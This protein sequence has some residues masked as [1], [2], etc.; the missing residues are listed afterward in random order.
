MVF[1]S[2]TRTILRSPE[3]FT[4]TCITR[5]TSRLSLQWAERIVRSEKDEE[6]SLLGDSEG[7]Q[8]IFTRPGLHRTASD[9]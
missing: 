9:E 3:T 5:V 4:V 8:D 6:R 7:H 2:G 1:N